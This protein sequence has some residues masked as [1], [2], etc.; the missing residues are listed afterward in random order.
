MPRIRTIKPEFPQSESIGR[1]GREARLLFVQLWTICDDYGRTRA[2]PRFL[3]G[4]L[5]P[6]DDDATKLLPKWL[7][8]LEREGLIQL[9][10]V[11]GSAYLAV[12]GWAKHQRVDNAGKEMVPPPP[13]TPPVDPA[14]IRGEPPTTADNRRDLPLDLGPRTTTKTKEGDLGRDHGGNSAAD[15]R[16]A[17]E[18]WNLTAEAARLPKVQHLTEARS[19]ATA[20]RLAECGGIEGWQAALAKVAASPFLC[21]DNDRGWRANF[22]FMIRQSS[23][24]KIMEG[25]YNGHARKPSGLMQA[26]ADLI[27]GKDPF[28]APKH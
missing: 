19:R 10:R 16:R 22:D 2:A 24:T 23:F 15:I 18:T 17:V 8:E 12:T 7:A 21:G 11:E 20:K 6:Y 27:A 13:P 3:A 14:E 1:I 28:D 4:Q 9:Y 26:A 25:G 5:Y